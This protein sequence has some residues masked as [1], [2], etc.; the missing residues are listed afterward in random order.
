MTDDGQEVATVQIVSLADHLALVGTISGWQWREWGDGEPPE[1][2]LDWRARLESRAGRELPFT[3]VALLNGAAVG[4]VSVC[5]DDFDEAFADNGPWLSGM[6]VRPAA[7]NLGVGRQL[8]LEVERRCRVRGVPEIWLHTGEAHR[9]YE[10]CGWTTMR[11][12]ASAGGPAV[13][14]R[15]L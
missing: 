10:R 3:L 8:L 13:L 7:R 12:K 4:S 14:R 2:E 6:L 1:A 15:R 5:N 9:F 11:R